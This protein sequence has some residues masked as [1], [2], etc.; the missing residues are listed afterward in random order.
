VFED[1]GVRLWHTRNDKDI[2]IVSFKSKMN[3]VGEEVINGLGAALERAERDFK[4]LVIWQPS[5][6]FSA[7]ANLK[8]VEAG[9]KAGEFA[10]LES[11]IA[12]GQQLVMRLKYSSI[13]TVAAVQ[14]LAFGGGC[15]LQMHC[16]RAVVAFESVI[17]LVEAGVG[18]IPG[19][20]GCAELALRS[21]QAAATTQTGDLLNF[22]QPL[23]MTIAMA[24]T[25]RSAP[26]AQAL[27]LVRAGDVVVMHPRE[28]LHV[29]KETARGMVEAGYRPKLPPRGIAVAGRGGVATLEMGLINMRDG[30]MISAHDYQVARASAV[31]LCGGEVEAGTLVDEQWL[32]NVERALFMTLLKT[33][34]TQQRIAH[35][36]ESGK[37][38][39][40]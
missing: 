16:A 28:L 13:P 14:G 37:P 1:E 31:A 21:A 9:I 8:A 29:A 33:V 27:G 23:H 11:Y 3:T 12:R 22:V 34:K 36:M 30:G 40:N 25:S 4:A 19:W 17:G 24:K 32:L 7:G 6:P 18:L 20:G 38:L 5:G 39:R 26:D 10:K 35:M 2:A 15:E